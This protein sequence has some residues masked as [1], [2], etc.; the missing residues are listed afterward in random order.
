MP[1]RANQ[2]V[3]D[4]HVDVLGARFPDHQLLRLKI[5]VE[6]VLEVGR[7][8]VRHAR[9]LGEVLREAFDVVIYLPMDLLSAVIALDRL[10][11]VTEVLVLLKIFISNIDPVVNRC[12]EVVDHFHKLG[13]VIAQVESLAGR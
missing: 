9:P 11:A 10:K 5:D 2:V 1:R 13:R 7:E 12:H 6:L 3:R 4:V 8:K